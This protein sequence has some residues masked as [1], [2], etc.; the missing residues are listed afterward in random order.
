MKT[1]ILASLAAA[2]AAVPALATHDCANPTPISGSV[3]VP[4]DLSQGQLDAPGINT[5]ASTT[6]GVDCNVAWSLSSQ[7]GDTQS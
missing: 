2:L 5:C 4:F 7:R 6:S 3:V 1:R